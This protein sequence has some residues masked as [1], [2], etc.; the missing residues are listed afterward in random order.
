M[1]HS[2][3][4][5]AYNPTNC[6]YLELLIFFFFSL[7]ILLLLLLLLLVPLGR[8]ECCALLVNIMPLAQETHSKRDSRSLLCSLVIFPRG[9][10]YYCDATTLS[11][12]FNGKISILSGRGASALSPVIGGAASDGDRTSRLP[13]ITA[14][15]PTPPLNTI[16]YGEHQ[17]P[18]ST[19]TTRVLCT[20]DLFARRVYICDFSSLR[21][22]VSPLGQ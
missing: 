22:V 6:D 11:R 8:I 14:D 19:A 18:A 20:L 9:G 13:L 21:R 1:S 17:S 12:A 2:P 5:L 10:G 16:F 15:S 7:F 4:A 3:W